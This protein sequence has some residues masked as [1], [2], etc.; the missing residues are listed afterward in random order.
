MRI[1][2]IQLD[3]WGHAALF[4]LYLG[5]VSVF[6]NLS[7]IAP[8]VASAALLGWLGLTWAWA[9]WA[10]LKMPR[11]PLPGVLLLVLGLLPYGYFIFLYTTGQPLVGAFSYFYKFAP[12]LLFPALYR[13]CLHHND[14]WI[15]RTLLILATVIALRTLIAFVI[16][17][18]FP[19][20]SGSGA[21]SLWD[22]V[23]IYEKIGPLARVFYPGVA[24]V[25][26]GLVMSVDRALTR[27]MGVRLEVARALMFL[28]ALGVSLTRGFLLTT[29]ALLAL[30]IAGRWVTTHV[31]VQRRFRAL[32]SAALLVLAAAVG[33]ATT[34]AGLAVGRTVEQYSGQERFSLDTKNIDWRA[35][36]AQLAFTLIQSSEQRWLGIGTNVSIPEDIK[37]PNPWEVTNE[38]HYSYHS[39][40]WTFGYLGLTLLTAGGL[41]LPALT[42]L[43]W[44]LRSTLAL[45]LGLTLVFIAVIG[46]YTI[47]FTN[48]DWNFMMTL[49]GAF[50][51]ARS[52]QAAARTYAAA[53][54][55]FLLPQPEGHFTLP[56]VP[57][58]RRPVP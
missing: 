23:V 36:Q 38:L 7:R 41:A 26:W 20:R 57:A 51:L 48:A 27:G 49:C 34:P 9:A 58:P 53:R 18:V 3:F 42:A 32:L 5:T 8:G 45:S 1:P 44:R 43:R 22:D 50:L 10:L 24:L 12:L 55:P 19:G 28:A 39:I 40:Q 47:V 2:R 52:R 4:S 15:E 54:S 13:W 17:G 46:S 21:A 33:L 56:P 25:F 16:P 37:S 35:E 30:Y 31:T 29:F 6:G 14:T 11:I